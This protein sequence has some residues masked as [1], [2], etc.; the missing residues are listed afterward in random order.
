MVIHNCQAKDQ[1]LCGK[2]FGKINKVSYVKLVLIFKKI[3]LSKEM[4][5]MWEMNKLT[6]SRKQ[7]WEEGHI[8]LQCNF[9]N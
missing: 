9:K 6:G 7:R 5:G 2:L 3:R 8:C 1:I 4:L